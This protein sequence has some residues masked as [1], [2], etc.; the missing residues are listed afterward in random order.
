MPWNH[1]KSHIQVNLIFFSF[2]VAQYVFH[3]LLYNIVPKN[4]S[5][6]HISEDN[7]NINGNL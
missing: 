7:N 4:L 5:E 1:A 3:H 6:G 2:N